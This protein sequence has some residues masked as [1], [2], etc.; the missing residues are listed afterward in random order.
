[1][2][3]EGTLPAGDLPPSLLAISLRR[4]QEI[5]N[6]LG[7]HYKKWG[8]LCYAVRLYQFIVDNDCV[9]HHV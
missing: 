4:T 5:D 9:F 1:M 8:I 2:L 3:Q 6:L 7:Q